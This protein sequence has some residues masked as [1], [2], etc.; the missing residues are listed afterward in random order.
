MKKDRLQG[1]DCGR[2]IAV[3]VVVFGH[4]HVPVQET[5]AIDIFARFAVPFFFLTSGYFFKVPDGKLLPALLKMTATFLLPFFVWLAIYLL[6]FQPPAE[7]FRSPIEIARLLIQGGPAYHLWFLPSLAV[8]S[9]LMLILLRLDIGERALILAAVGLYLTGLVLGPYYQVLV[10]E[11]DFIWNMRDGPFLGFPFLVIGWYLA[12]N[13]IRPSLQV[14]LAVLAFGACLN[15]AEILTMDAFHIEFEHDLLI[16]T[17]PY[18][19]GFF[20]VALAWPMNAAG[21]LL[22]RIG[23]YS[24]GIYCVHLLVIEAIYSVIGRYDG[25][26]AKYPALVGAAAILISLALCWTGARLPLFSPFFRT[27]KKM[28]SSLVKTRFDFR[29]APTQT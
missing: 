29:R 9:A 18:G 23:P 3:L 22:A 21:Q 24:L 15:A 10:G 19:V 6:W 1:I 14:S 12:R 17:I 11:G 2:A 13:S 26:E 27:G 25:G 4:A 8:S 16:G 28:K 20:L 5:S 7:V